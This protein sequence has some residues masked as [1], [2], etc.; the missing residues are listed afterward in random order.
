MIGRP[1][2]RWLAVPPLIIVMALASVVLLPGQPTH[3]SRGVTARVSVD[4][5][6]NQGNSGSFYAALSASCISSGSRA[7]ETDV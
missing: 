5:A 7:S 2:A 6:R 4:S 3:A 1:V